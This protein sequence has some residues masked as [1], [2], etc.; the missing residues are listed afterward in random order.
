VV[1]HEVVHLLA[2]K[3]PHRE[4]GLMA[5]CAN[6]RELVAPTMRI[7]P[8]LT[9]IVQAA[10]RAGKDTPRTTATHFARLSAAGR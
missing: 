10:L 5:A 3:L 7:E 1:A 6:A 2:P 8:E 9:A 4:E